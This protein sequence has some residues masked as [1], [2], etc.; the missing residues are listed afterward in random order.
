VDPKESA[1]I[2]RIAFEPSCNA[3]N[4]S[5]TFKT[6]IAFEKYHVNYES[7]TEP[8]TPT[9]TVSA[10]PTQTPTATPTPTASATPTPTPTKI[11]PAPIKYKN[12]TEAKAAGVTPILRSTD[13]ELYALNSS[14]DGDKDGDACEN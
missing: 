2:E 13:P 8:S 14:L 7:P 12:C 4:A 5:K 1:V 6:L 11:K 3:R 9:P 10:T